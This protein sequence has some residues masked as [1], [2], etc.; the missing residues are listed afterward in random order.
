[1]KPLILASASPRRRALLTLLDCDFEA[2]TAHVDETPRAGENA[3]QVAMRLATEKARTVAAARPNC[4]VLGAD[5]V[6]AMD[7]FIF[8]KPADVAQARAWLAM[9]SGREHR[10]IT[11]LMLMDGERCTRARVVTHLWFRTLDAGEIANY[12][13]TPG[14]RD[15]AGAYAVQ[16][17]AAVFVTRLVGSYTNVVGLPLAATAALLARIPAG[18]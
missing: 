8:G 17:G 10:V 16:G 11:A 1:M 18:A 12:A 13:R 5:T 6:V 2:C 7:E 3:E 15:A 4:R 14:S 9:L